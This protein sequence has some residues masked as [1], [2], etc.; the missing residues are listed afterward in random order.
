[1]ASR[2]VGRLTPSCCA[3]SFSDGSREPGGIEPLWI[4][5]RMLSATCW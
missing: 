1:M 4:C 2:T 5:L 3:R